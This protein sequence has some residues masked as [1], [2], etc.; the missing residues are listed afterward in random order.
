MPRYF[1]LDEAVAQIEAFNDEE[2]D[3][4]LVII[5]PD[6]DHLSDDDEINDDETLLH[7]PTDVPGSVEVI[8]YQ[9]PDRDED[10][11]TPSSGRW[12]SQEEPTYS[13][14]REPPNDVSAARLQARI[15]ALAQLDEVGVFEKIV[16]DSFIDF[17]VT[18]TN[19][20][21]AVDK[22]DHTFSTN[23]DEI[24]TFIAIL[25]MSGYHT[26]P[27]QDLYWSVSPDLSIDIVRNAM[28]RDRFRLLKKYFHVCN[29]QQV[30]PG[31]K[32]FKVKKFLD[33]LNDRFMQW[34]ICEKKFQ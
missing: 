31:D 8:N 18:E 9:I 22:N 7:L 25:I 23:R 29:N 5:P 10:Q 14:F 20:Y 13:R 15:A 26:L 6:P 33:L 30:V 16:D 12:V 4:G 3:G 32:S 2:N 24:R 1:S 19:R 21:A 11:E 28:S 17:I 27:Q 34:G